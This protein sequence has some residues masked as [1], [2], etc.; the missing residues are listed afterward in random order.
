MEPLPIGLI[1]DVVPQSIPIV[2]SQ[3][4]TQASGDG[5]HRVAISMRIR[6]YYGDEFQREQ[7]RHGGRIAVRDVGLLIHSAPLAY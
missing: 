7:P 4:Q 6:A 1:A 5:L 3:F 2:D